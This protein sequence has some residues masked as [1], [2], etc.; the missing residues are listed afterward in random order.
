MILDYWESQAMNTKGTNPQMGKL[1]AIN[2]VNIRKY[3]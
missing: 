1:H 3:R 2:S